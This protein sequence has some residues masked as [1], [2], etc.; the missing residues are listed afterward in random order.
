MNKFFAQNADCHDWITTHNIIASDFI[1]HNIQNIYSVYINLY[2]VL[3]YSS[4]ILK[5]G[6]FNALYTAV[7]MIF[8]HVLFSCLENM[9]VAMMHTFDRT[10]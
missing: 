6:S 1:N 5:N 3:K 4:A 8:Y 7:V 10:F 9:E 2:I